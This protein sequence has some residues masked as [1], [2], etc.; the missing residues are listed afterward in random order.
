MRVARKS[1]KTLE[2]K[3]IAWKIRE[4]RHYK[5]EFLENPGKMLG[6]HLISHLSSNIKD[7]VIV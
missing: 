5:E 1:C 6:L 2:K 4:T 7:L 3:T